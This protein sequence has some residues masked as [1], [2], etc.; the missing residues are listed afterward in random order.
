MGPYALFSCPEKN[1]GLPP[2]TTDE[3]DF[4][5]K[6]E[7]ITLGDSPKMKKSENKIYHF[8][9]ELANAHFKTFQGPF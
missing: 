8:E 6:W 5:K 3:I 9:R 2:K 1:R 4:E 7:K